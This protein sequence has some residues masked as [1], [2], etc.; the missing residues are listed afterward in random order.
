MTDETLSQAQ[1]V[2]AK[3]GGVNAAA[4]LLGHRNASTVQGWL[5]RGTIPV[6]R[7]PEVLEKAQGAGVQLTKQDFV[8][9]LPDFAVN[10]DQSP[11]PSRD[12]AA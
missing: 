6:R 9:H 12:A 1:H 11:N 7:H 5:E 10:V 8:A 4:R 3:L 2:I